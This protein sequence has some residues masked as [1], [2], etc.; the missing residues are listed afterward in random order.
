[1]ATLPLGLGACHPSPGIVPAAMPVR[2][3]GPNPLQESVAPP[4]VA[5]TE[6]VHCDQGGNFP[7]SAANLRPIV[8]VDYIALRSASGVPSQGGSSEWTQTQFEVLSQHGALCGS[9]PAGS[10]CKEQAAHH[11]ANFVNAQC[12]QICREIS[13]VTTRGGEVRRWATPQELRDF[14]APIDTV[15]EALLIAQAEHY[16]VS[17]EAESSGARR[18]VDGYEVYATRMTAMCAPMITTGYWLRVS[19]AG[20]VSEISS[21]ERSRSEACVGRMPRG[22]AACEPSNERDACAGF[23]AQSSYLEAASV[24][25]FEQ[26]AAEL[27]ELGAPRDLVEA[28]ERASQEE[29]I[30]A[31]EVSELACAYGASP[32]T[33]PLRFARAPEGAHRRQPTEKRDLEEIALENVVEGC[34]R[35]TYGAMIGAFQSVRAGDRRV[36]KCMRAIAEEELG[37]ARLSHQVHRWIMPRLG[38]A[39]RTRVQEAMAHAV[40][41]LRRSVQS[42]SPDR[43]LQSALGL[44]DRFA[45][46]LLLNQLEQDLWQ[47]LGAGCTRA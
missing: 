39:A 1:M 24:L 6:R 27:A 47:P 30:H 5:V 34:V 21:E 9:A 36:Q 7:V 16:N 15:D 17:C 23:L 37:H 42:T 28:A 8:P 43:E 35:E 22:L 19:N 38:A 13:V 46:S 31:R 40:S 10:N 3:S 20:E 11:P 33:A 4:P 26:L 45:A 14:L 32:L 44:P 41:S 12:L 2:P 18:T 29:R 25:A